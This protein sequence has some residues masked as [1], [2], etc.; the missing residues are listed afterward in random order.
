MTVQ[1]AKSEM[2]AAATAKLLR[3]ERMTAMATHSTLGNTR[4]GAC[5]F[6]P[7]FCCNLNSI[8]LWTK[9]RNH[10]KLEQQIDLFFK[11][12]QKCECKCKLYRKRNER[13]NVIKKRWKHWWMNENKRMHRIKWMWFWCGS[14]WPATHWA[15]HSPRC[16]CQFGRAWTL[17]WCNDPWRRRF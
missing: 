17:W 13:T 4:R 11:S 16:I 15:L 14:G 5:E 6:L 2:A 9:W 10:E 3:G 1:L 7:R 8:P 12:T